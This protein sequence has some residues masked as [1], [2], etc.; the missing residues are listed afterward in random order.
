MTVLWARF[1][2]SGWRGIR[3]KGVLGYLLLWWRRKA[4]IR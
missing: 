2:L 3:L 4:L 1:R